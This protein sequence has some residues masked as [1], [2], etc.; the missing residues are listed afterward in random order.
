MSSST[1]RGVRRGSAE[2]AL[3]RARH[4]R[5][6]N[7]SEEPPRSS[8][9]F[10]NLPPDALTLVLK[11]AR[12][13][14]DIH[15]F[16]FAWSMGKICKTL[17]EHDILDVL[18]AA[19]FHLDDF[20][21]YTALAR[22]D[23][24]PFDCR[25][26]LLQALVDDSTKCALISELNI[27]RTSI[28]KHD[29][30][31]DSG[32][33]KN[34]GSLLTRKGVFINA[35]ELH[36][37]LTPASGESEEISS[38]TNIP[39]LT[40]KLLR[41]MPNAFPVVTDVTFGHC[42]CPE[43][44]MAKKVFENFFGS[45]QLPLQSIDLKRIPFLHERH[46]VKILPLIGSSLRRIEIN[47]AENESVKM[48]VGQDDEYSLFSAIGENCKRLK[49]LAL[50]RMHFYSTD[51]YLRTI[52]DSIPGLNELVLKGNDYHV[53]DPRVAA[54]DYISGEEAEPYLAA[55]FHHRGT[56]LETLKCDFSDGTSAENALIS[57]ITLQRRN[58][59][60]SETE[61]APESMKLRTVDIPNLGVSTIA[62]AIGSGVK[63]FV[64]Y[65]KT[66]LSARNKI[67]AI[68]FAV[69][70]GSLLSEATHEMVYF[71]FC[72]LPGIFYTMKFDDRK[73]IVEVTKT[74]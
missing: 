17:H 36:I 49:S 9:R 30:K 20:E 24:Q 15:Q 19:P 7:N 1:C 50:C 16:E 55:F 6:D 47:G 72:K 43:A 37:D 69:S 26:G 11:Y 58:S 52:F 5:D 46:V 51:V 74:T 18:P 67:E 62:I 27:S 61:G 54:N 66:M 48:V 31:V 56:H 22:N 12:P 73:I 68:A 71:H 13:L 42:F 45:L 65:E 53:Y 29:G 41:Q 60:R 28:E 57:L 63:D 21:E 14:D 4:E 40:K 3:K 38:T 32:I 10:S 64:M 35:G 2:P 70:A 59:S 34:L 8:D 39:F 23:A 44:L 25:A 33:V